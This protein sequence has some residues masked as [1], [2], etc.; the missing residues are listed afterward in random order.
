MGLKILAINPGSTSTKLA[1]YEDAEE[2]WRAAVAH[3]AEDLSRFARIGDQ[4]EYRRGAVREALAASPFAS[5]GFAAVVGR[6]GLLKPLAGGVYEVNARMKADLAAGRYGN[7]ASNLGALIADTL[8][9][10]AGVKAWIVDPVVV[11]ELSPLARISGL[12]EVPRRSIFHALNQKATARKAAAAIGRR[13]EEC[14]LVVAH[15]GGGTSIGLHENGRVVD[16]NNALDGEGPFAIERAGTLPAG[17]WMRY[18]LARQHHGIDLQ[19]LLTGR[20]GLVAW[21]GTNDFPA[22]EQAAAAWRAAGGAAE[23][24]GSGSGPEPP[25]G[26]RLDGRRCD[27]LI[28]AMCY[29]SAKAIAGLAAG[30]SGRVHAVVLTGGLAKSERVVEEIRARVAFLAPVLVYPGENEL[31]ALALGVLAV[32]RGEAEPRVYEGAPA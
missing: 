25:A 4:L 23:A 18:V 8:A 31:E 21:L 10:E 30:V 19:A 7:H 20:G 15:L 29:A 17:D 26:R 3:G 24:P 27:E 2:L 9:R 14:A 22:I 13:Y 28:S 12:P 1:V 11:D 6:G 16:V 32:L 5:G